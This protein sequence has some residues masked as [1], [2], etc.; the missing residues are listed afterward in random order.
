MEAKNNVPFHYNY[1]LTGKVHADKAESSHRGLPSQAGH[2]FTNPSKARANV[3]L[4]NGKKA[5]D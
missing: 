3:T 1:R 5:F 4:P 2:G